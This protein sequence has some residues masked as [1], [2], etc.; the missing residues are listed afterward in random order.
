MPTPLE[1]SIHRTVAWFSLFEIPVTAFEAWKWMLAPDRTYRLEEVYAALE[2]EWLRGRLAGA[3]GMWTLVEA[4]N[5]TAAH[6][7]ERFLDAARKYG[8]LRRAARYLARVPG[9]EAVAAANTLALWD[10]R[11]DSDIDLF[12]IVRPGTI[13]LARLLMVTPFA[14]TGKRPGASSEDPFCFSFFATTDA[15]DLAALR[16]GEGD[17]YLAYWTRSLVPVIDR[18]AFAAFG[19]G[20]AWASAVLPHARSKRAH[21]V[22]AARP[23]RRRAASGLG[24]RLEPLARRLQLRRFPARIRDLMNRDSRVVVNDAMLKFHDN[25]RRAHYRDRLNALCPENASQP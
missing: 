2:G 3:N 16:V 12:V 10:T 6:R 11:P 15:L 24:T 5:A 1:Q 20:N 8:R 14:L 22:L 23:G 19:E 4:S 18:G 25:D 13:W 9:V 7:R 17:P 21:A